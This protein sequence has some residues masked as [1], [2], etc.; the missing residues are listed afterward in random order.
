M[1]C[2]LYSGLIL[3]RTNATRP[4][5]AAIS[6]CVMPP[7]GNDVG[8]VRT[9]VKEEVVPPLLE[10]NVQRVIFD[11]YPR[12]ERDHCTI[13]MYTISTSLRNSVSLDFLKMEA[14]A[15]LAPNF[16]LRAEHMAK[17]A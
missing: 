12:K 11:I 13:Q 16:L 15:C 9:G 4:V 7:S 5:E 1:H 6:Y 10:G 8:Q 2:A 14:S 3:G 17:R